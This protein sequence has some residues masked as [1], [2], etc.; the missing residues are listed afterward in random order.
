MPLLETL[1]LR[2]VD[3]IVD[4]VLDTAIGRALGFR[5]RRHALLELRYA[6]GWASDSSGVEYPVVVRNRGLQKAWDVIVKCLH[7]GQVT[8]SKLIREINAESETDQITL[9]VP[10][11][12]CE[13]RPGVG[14]IPTGNVTFELWHAGRR[15][16]AAGLD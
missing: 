14:Q 11:G 2:A 15:V 1:G 9:R 10:A 8:D 16:G 6:G 3:R 12:Q 5:S 13:L 4:R 7:D